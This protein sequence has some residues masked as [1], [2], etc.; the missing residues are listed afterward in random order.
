[1]EMQVTYL[2]VSYQKPWCCEET[3]WK[4]H[5][6]LQKKITAFDMTNSWQ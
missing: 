1:M 4:G 2:P 6:E 5:I 3:T